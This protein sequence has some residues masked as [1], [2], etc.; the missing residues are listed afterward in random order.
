MTH[1]TVRIG[2]DDEKNLHKLR[3]AWKVN[4]SEATRMALET[5]A[6]IVEKKKNKKELLAQSSFIGSIRSTPSLRTRYKK[7]IRDSILKKH[8]RKS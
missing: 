5:A 7:K 4:R 3:K 2:P 8:G 1:I 6:A